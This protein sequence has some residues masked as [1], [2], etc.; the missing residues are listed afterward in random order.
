MMVPLSEEEQRILQEME[1]KLREHDRD[2]VERVSHRSDR[3]QA[4]RGLKWSVFAF[5]GGTALLLATFRFSLALGVCGVLVMVVAALSFAQQV[6]P[7]NR[8]SLE[9][10]DRPGA[11]GKPK[12][13]IAEEWSQ[14]RRRMRSRFGH[15]D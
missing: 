3:L 15:R 12:G 4:G 1:Q 5:L 7:P 13:A 11:R 14:I 6:A 9:S 10:E 8:D 2:F